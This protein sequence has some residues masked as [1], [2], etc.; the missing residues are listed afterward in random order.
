MHIGAPILLWFPRADNLR[1][2][3]YEEAGF[4]MSRAERFRVARRTNAATASTARAD[5]ASEKFSLA[6]Q[7]E[8]I[9]FAAAFSVAARS[10]VAVTF[11]IAAA[12][13]AWSFSVAFTFA[14]R[15]PGLRAEGNA[16]PA[17]VG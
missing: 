16:Q 2:P 15:E 17:L 8:S 9:A 14:G 12:H 1:V 13:A 3:F 11:A 7:P 4:R 5:A 10:T 6:H